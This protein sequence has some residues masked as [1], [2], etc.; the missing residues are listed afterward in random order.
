MDAVNVMIRGVEQPTQNKLCERM[1][2]QE[3]RN[4]NRRTMP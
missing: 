2:N 3:R 4:V 1:G